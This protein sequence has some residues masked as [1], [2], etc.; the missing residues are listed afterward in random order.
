MHLARGAARPRA[1]AAGSADRAPPPPPPS[2]PLARRGVLAGGAAAAAGALHAAAGRALE[3]EGAA[4]PAPP[5][6]TSVAA[7][8]RALEERVVDF[9]LPNGLKVLVI[10]RRGAPVVACR[11]YADVG[12]YDEADGQT[13]VAHFLEHLLFKGTP[14]LGARDFKAEAP[15]LDALDE[16]FYEARGAPPGSA[17]A[18]AA[19]ARLARLEVDAAALAEANAFGS[20]LERAG[21]VGLN[22]ATSHDSTQFFCA[23][24]ANKLE[25]WFALEAERFRAPVFR[26]LYSEKR[27]VLEERRQRVDAAPLGHFQEAFA[28]AALGN[29]YRRPVI[30]FQADIE[31][32]GR[33]E[34]ATFFARRYVPANLTLVVAGDARPEKV[35][36]LAERYFGG[37]EYSA[38]AGDGLLAAS[39]VAKKLDA[40]A[41]RPA[42]GAPRELVMSS[43]AGPALLRGFYRGAGASPDAGALDLLAD[44]LSGAR[45]ARLQR[46]LVQKGLALGAGASPALPADKRASLFAVFASPPAGARREKDLRALDAVVGAQLAALAEAGPTTAEITRYN[47]A[48]RVATLSALQSNSAAA[49]A[50]APYAALDA[51]GWRGLVRDLEAAEALTP[52]GARDVAARLFDPS[53]SF[54]GLVNAA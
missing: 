45:S 34:V 10:A 35:R 31:A 42:A 28:A 51:L 11:S 49:G 53:N 13:G 6:T 38:A 30:G 22:A 20:A 1:C 15:L 41:A 26:G 52:G 12:A 14:R 16:A 2:P 7:L 48:A 4:P 43:P 54:L 9:R 36:Q 40:D 24:P 47:R 19:A 17:A 3:A 29:N 27:V 25:L 18:A 50:L 44:A 8:A 32:L 5:S 23:L 46:A 21:A 39:T 33:R 37:W